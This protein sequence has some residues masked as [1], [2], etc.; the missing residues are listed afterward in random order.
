MNH[1]V[2]DQLHKS[3]L[4]K[5]CGNGDLISANLLTAPRSNS[6]QNQSNS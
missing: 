6:I 4:I 1:V 2:T 3:L 5:R